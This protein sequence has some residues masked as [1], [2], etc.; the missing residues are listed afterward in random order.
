LKHD[1]TKIFEI[2]GPGLCVRSLF[3]AFAERDFYYPI[4]ALNIEEQQVVKKENKYIA[5]T[6][7][8]FLPLELCE[9]VIDY[10]WLNQCI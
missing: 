6:L 10:Y 2:I 5:D 9:I 7:D 3:V 1:Y 8:A 4:S